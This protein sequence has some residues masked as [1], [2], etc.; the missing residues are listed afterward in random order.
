VL[1]IGVVVV[2]TAASKDQST[3]DADAKAEHPRNDQT[4]QKDD[5]T[6]HPKPHRD[7]APGQVV[8]IVM[9]ALKDNDTEDTGIAITFEFASPENKKMTGPLK[10]F[11][12]M[13]KSPAYAPMLNHKSATYGKVYVK[14]D[15]AQTFVR[16]TDTT[17]R[18]T[19]YAFRLSKQHD[20]GEFKDCWMTDGVVPIDPRDL[21]PGADEEPELDDAAG[22]DR[23]DRT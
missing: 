23:P 12:P 10:R 9:G 4:D 13:V 3:A 8:R 21:P 14:D 15:V 11:I 2:F 5:A 16:V 18:D 7:L 1:V 20:E 19:L 17:D 22:P 6:K